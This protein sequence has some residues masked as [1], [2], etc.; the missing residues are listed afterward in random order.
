MAEK[1]FKDDLVEVVLTSTGKKTKVHRIH[2]NTLV[3]NGTATI[4]GAEPKKTGR[5]RK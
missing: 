5:S 4:V 2:A 1:V 3:A